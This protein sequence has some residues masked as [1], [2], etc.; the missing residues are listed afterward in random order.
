MMQLKSCPSLKE[1][2]LLD[3]VCKE[4]S[5]RVGIVAKNTKKSVANLSGAITSRKSSRE[6]ALE[7]ESKAL[8]K[9]EEEHLKALDKVRLERMKNV[10]LPNG[11][12][13]VYSFVG[14][15]Q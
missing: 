10:L 9:A 11:I 12:F 7:D 1:I 5:T 3:A 8:R 4:Y 2:E 14:A 6:K 13:F 15:Q